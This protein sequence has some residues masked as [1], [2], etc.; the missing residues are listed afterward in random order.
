MRKTIEV[1]V[2]LT[3]TEIIQCLPHL[4]PLDTAQLLGHLIKA[5]TDEQWTQL[6]EYVGQ[7]RWDAFVG[8]LSRAGKSEE[9][10]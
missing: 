10:R 8:R 2:E 1:E 3:P 9:A 4:G 7:E 6:M 5:N